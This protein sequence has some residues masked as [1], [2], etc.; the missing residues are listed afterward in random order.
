ML[1]V[2]DEDRVRSAAVEVVYSDA[3]R[4]YVRGSFQNGTQLIKE[5]PHRV[6][7]GQSVRVTEGS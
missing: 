7:P 6:A 1:V 3:D 4:A 5:G 2:D